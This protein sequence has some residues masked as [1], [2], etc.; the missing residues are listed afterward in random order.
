V[1]FPSEGGLTVIILVEDNEI[2]RLPPAQASALADKDVLRY[3]RD[4][5]ARI[6][7]EDWA[8]RIW[9]PDYTREQLKNAPP[10]L[11]SAY[12]AT[13]KLAAGKSPWIAISNGTKGFSGELPP[14]A[15]SLLELLK[16]FG[17]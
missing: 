9:D 8:T 6:T 12:E 14:D 2:G 5:S 7:P 13:V 16:K 10:A 4:K 17:G 3:L 11:V 15:A 1:P